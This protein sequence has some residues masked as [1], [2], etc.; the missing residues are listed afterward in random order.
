[1]CLNNT[2][3]L[4]YDW[5]FVSDVQGAG[6]LERFEKFAGDSPVDGPIEMS[7]RRRPLIPITL[8][9]TAYSQQFLRPVC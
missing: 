9:N 8:N 2:W 6:L 7:K 1:M 3:I 5:I 4:S